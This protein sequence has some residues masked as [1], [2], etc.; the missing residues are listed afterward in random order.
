MVRE[1]LKTINHSYQTLRLHIFILPV[2]VNEKKKW[3]ET[4]TKNSQ[5]F[6]NTFCA[7][8]NHV[9]SR[10]IF[11]IELKVCYKRVGGLVGEY[12]S[13]LPRRDVLE[14]IKRKVWL[15]PFNGH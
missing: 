10:D 11:D 3:C 9:N 14:S 2:L 13:C 8:I 15:P 6:L 7:K 4:K 12:N 5:L 1:V